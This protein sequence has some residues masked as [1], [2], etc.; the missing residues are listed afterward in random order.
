MVLVVSLRTRGSVILGGRTFLGV[1]VVGVDGVATEIF[2]FYAGEE[3]GVYGGSGFAE[4]FFS[5][6]DEFLVAEE[7]EEF[8]VVDTEDDFF[9]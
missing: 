3:L 2:G 7:D 5:E 1:F 9:L 8:L 6:G 4:T